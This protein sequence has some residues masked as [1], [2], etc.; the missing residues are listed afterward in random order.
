MV[1]AEWA[2]FVLL[3]DWGWKGDRAG[4]ILGRGKKGD[5]AER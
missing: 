1:F 2:R 3:R 5:K 4:G